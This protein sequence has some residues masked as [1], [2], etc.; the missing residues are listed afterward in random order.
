[1]EIRGRPWDSSKSHQRSQCHIPWLKITCIFQHVSLASSMSFWVQGTP[2]PFVVLIHLF[3]YNNNEIFI[4][5]YILGWNKPIRSEEEFTEKYKRTQQ[6][7]HLEPGERTEA[8]NIGMNFKISHQLK[9]NTVF[10]LRQNCVDTVSFLN[11]VF[12]IQNLNYSSSDYITFFEVNFKWVE[13]NLSIQKTFECKNF[14][15]IINTSKK[16]I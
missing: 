10:S 12:W 7:E 4:C 8:E 16:V 9:Q 6:W 14:L 5:S 11:L 1:M 15:S 3:C 2:S 13:L